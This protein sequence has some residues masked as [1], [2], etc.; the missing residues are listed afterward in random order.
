VQVTLIRHTAD[1]VQ[2]ATLAAKACVSESLHLQVKGNQDLVDSVYES[3]HES[4]LEHIVFTFGIEGISRALLAQLTRH[5][6][7]SYAAQSQRSVKLEDI[8]FIEPPTIEGYGEE[9]IWVYHVALGTTRRAYEKL[10][11]LGIP[12]EDA[13]Y[14]LPN[15]TST[16]LVV[17]VNLRELIHVANLR[18]CTRAQWEIRQ[19]V[20]EMRYE[21]DK[22]SPEVAK[23][24]VPQCERLGFCPEKKGCGR[25]PQKGN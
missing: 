4:I 12:A 9:A 14:L 8:K 2:L 23:Y 1:P 11:E 13:R 24:L 17:T 21:V 22:V 10:L 3:G 19:L 25:Y 18:L 6:M 5:R 7:A 20:S 16:N 15:A